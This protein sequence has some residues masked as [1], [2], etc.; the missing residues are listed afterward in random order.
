VLHIGAAAL[1]GLAIG[2]FLRRLVDQ[3]P[4][5]RPLFEPDPAELIPVA[6][7]M[8][9][10]PAGSL[11]YV[12]SPDDR[13]DD[14]ST[15][16]L[17][18]RAPLID[19]G[20]AAVLALL[21]ARIGWSPDLP[22]FLVF[23]AALVV[24][25]VIDIDHYRIP[26]RVVF[27]TFVL[28]LVLLAAASMA[29]GEWAGLMAGLAGAAAYFV[30]LFVFFFIWPRGMG[31]GDVKLA[32]VLGLHVA[33][34]GSVAQVDGELVYVG[35]EFGLRLVLMGALFG[36]MLGAVLGLGVLLV[37]GRKGAFP[38]G[39]ALCVGALVAVLL[40]ETILN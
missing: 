7:W 11:V 25:A 2:P 28:T 32:L 12:G 14:T 8:A 23:G 9:R 18:W 13:T 5:R 20:A 16:V 36:S 6:S 24:I 26:D 35:L 4:D 40:S 3:V 22:A 1:L 10:E 38:F 30:F 19:L 33:W 27:P 39:P 29:V 21:A 34:A 37:W 17:R 31:F 15:R